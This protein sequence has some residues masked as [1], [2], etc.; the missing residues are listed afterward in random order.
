LFFFF[1]EK[2][3]NNYIYFK[4]F[5]HKHVRIQTMKFHLYYLLNYLD[6]YYYFK[7]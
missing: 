5:K 6:H 4:V 2:L 3:I 7:L 1:N